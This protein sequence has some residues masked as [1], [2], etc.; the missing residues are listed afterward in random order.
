[1]RAFLAVAAAVLVVTPVWA[2][3]PPLRKK[4][5]LIA[6]KKS[7]GPEGN[8][9]HDYGR[10]PHRRLAAPPQSGY[11]PC[12]RDEPVSVE[13]GPPSDS[14]RVRM[15]SF[16]GATLTDL[17]G[18]GIRKPRVRQGAGPEYPGLGQFAGSQGE[19]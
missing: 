7:H 16:N 8:G 10:G 17:A 4:I 9:I 11:T 19:K 1:M 14:V 6:S 13:S 2:A 3:A 5:V 18:Q 15:S 12:Q